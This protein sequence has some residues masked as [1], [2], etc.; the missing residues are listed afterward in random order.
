VE[1]SIRDF[2]VFALSISGGA[3]N[4]VD[5][6]YIAEAAYQLS[7]ERFQWKYFPERIDL[8]TVQYAL[9]D[10][11]HEKPSRIRGSIKHGYQL[12]NVGLTW[13]S[14]VRELPLIS[15]EDNDIAISPMK[16]IRSERHRLRNTS[17]YAKYAK[18]ASDELTR[19][20]FESFVR[21]NSYFPSHL[22]DERMQR[23]QN[24][25]DGDM[26]LSKLWKILCE[27]FTGDSSGQLNFS[28]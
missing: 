28:N 15:A 27:K 8:R 18:G 14:D 13:V 4:K 26:D 17:A 25:V 16:V 3:T 20:D 10:C 5:I 2:V 24:V 12:T 1:I 21:V 9:K 11:L 7:P 6:E 19:R 22:R 23:V